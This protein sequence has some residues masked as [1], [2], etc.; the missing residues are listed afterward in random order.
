MDAY[1][2]VLPAGMSDVSSTTPQALVPSQ[3]ATTLRRLQQ[4]ARDLRQDCNKLR[5]LQ[6]GNSNIMRD[7]HTGNFLEDQGRLLPQLTI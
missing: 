2:V 3:M 6:L 7:H 1:A 5:K 4:Q